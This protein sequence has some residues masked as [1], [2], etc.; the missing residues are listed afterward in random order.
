MF[1]QTLFYAW[2]SCQIIQKRTEDGKVKWQI[3]NC[4]LLVKNYW[5][6]MENQLSSSGI[7]SQDLHHCR[8]CRGS[9]IIWKN[10]T[11]NLKILEIGLS[12]CQCS[13]TLNGQ[14]KETKG[15]LRSLKGKETIHFKADAWNTELLFRIIHSAKQLSIYGAVSD[16]S[17]QFDLRSNERVP[18][19]ERSTSKEDSVNKE[20]LKSVNSQEVNSLVCAPRTEPSSGNRLREN[21]Q[22][23]ELRSEASQIT[24]LHRS[25]TR[26]KLV[27]TTRPFLT[28]TTVLKFSPQH[29]ENRHFLGQTHIPEP[30]QQF[31]EEQ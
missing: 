2:E 18:T 10:G 16:W 15:I 11:L 30:M 3:F 5:E 4:P 6:E 19:S 8:F 21:L 12:S 22:N 7:L 31:Q 23:F 14:E 26:S 17:E 28:W 24:N 9:R 25:G 1:T 20:I 29:A 13:T 27:C